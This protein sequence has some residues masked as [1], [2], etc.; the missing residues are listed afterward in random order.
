MAFV[1]DAKSFLA[2]KVIR[3]LW[4]AVIEYIQYT[5]RIP[6]IEEFVPTDDEFNE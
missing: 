5:K 4:A 6:L 3:F 2:T 1:E